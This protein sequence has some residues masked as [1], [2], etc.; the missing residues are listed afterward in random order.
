M[1]QDYFMIQMME[2]MRLYQPIMMMNLR[3]MPK[4]SIENWRS[5]PLISTALLY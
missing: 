5:L 4:V 1:H 2:D 3:P